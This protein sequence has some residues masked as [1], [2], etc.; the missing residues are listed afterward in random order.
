MYITLGQFVI[1]ANVGL[2]AD[3]Y[4]VILGRLEDRAAT[5]IRRRRSC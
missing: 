5:E 1:M 4:W 3:S 2:G